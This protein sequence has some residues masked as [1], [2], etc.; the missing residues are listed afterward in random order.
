MWVLIGVVVDSFGL[1]FV[2]RGMCGKGM[3]DGDEV[4]GDYVGWDV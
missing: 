2:D 3:S 1:P 4:E